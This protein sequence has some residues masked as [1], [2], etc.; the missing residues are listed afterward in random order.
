MTY[1]FQINCIAVDG[2]GSATVFATQRAKFLESFLLRT[3]CM[4]II[5]TNDSESLSKNYTNISHFLLLIRNFLSNVVAAAYSKF[6][7]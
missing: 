7:H 4:S 5:K 2:L 6:E 1:I 3:V